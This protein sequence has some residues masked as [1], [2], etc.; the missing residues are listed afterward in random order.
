MMKNVNATSSHIDPLI[1]TYLIV[2]F[3][4]RTDDVHQRH[5]FYKFDFFWNCSNPHHVKYVDILPGHTTISIVPASLVLYHTLARFLLCFSIHN[6]SVSSS[7]SRVFVS[8]KDITWLLFNSVIHS[9]RSQ[10]AS[11]TDDIF[12]YYILETITLHYR[13]NFY[14][15]S[16]SFGRFTILSHF[17]HL[18]R[19]LHH[20]CTI[21]S[22]FIS[23][24]K[25]CAYRVPF[26]W[27]L[28][29]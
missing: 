20:S 17:Y 7:L 2:T 9:F 26:I 19:R 8:P 23:V 3:I 1:H 28:L 12:K 24:L 16:G 10:L 25:P 27:C 13:V 29:L 4:M 6:T 15:S 22:T 21:I 5:L 14:I 11:W 18:L